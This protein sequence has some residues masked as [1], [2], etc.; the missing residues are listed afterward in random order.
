MTSGDNNPDP[1][2]A[3]KSEALAAAVKSA[4]AAIEHVKE[5]AAG[6]DFDRLRSD[7]EQ[8]R[9]RLADAAATL[10]R[11]GRERPA[12]SEELSKAGAEVSST[13]RRN[14][15][16]AVAVAFLAGLIL[17]LIARG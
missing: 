10:Y 16:A 15:L 2:R 6:A 5:L 17:A 4:E 11:E 14:P 1:D 9:S 7:L 13:I 3:S 8:L 12:G